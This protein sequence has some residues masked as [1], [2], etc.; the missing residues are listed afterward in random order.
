MTDII[1]IL[2]QFNDGCMGCCGHSFI[3][4]EKIKEAIKK[5]TLEFRELNPQTESQLMRFRDRATPMDLR[6]GVC[7]NLIEKEGKVFCPLHPKQNNGRE[8]R[9]GHCDINHLCRTAKEFAGWD[10]QKQEIFLKFIK[11]KK[12][13]NLEY[14]MGIEKGKFLEEFKSL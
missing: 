13:G 3:S 2:C 6:D 14:S 4:K 7:R 5:N 8:L 1:S 12:I 10:K 11:D 9:E